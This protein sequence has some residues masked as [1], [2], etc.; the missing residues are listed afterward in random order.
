VQYRL[1]PMSATPPRVRRA[2]DEP[3]ELHDYDPLWPQRFEQEARHLR[4]LLP[5]A[6][7]GRIAHFGSTAIP[8]MVA[9][10]IVDMLVEVPSLRHVHEVIAPLLEKQGYEYFWRASWQNPLLPAYTW[11]I[12]RDAQ[13]RRTHHIHL[14]TPDAPEWERLLFRDYLMAHPPVAQAYGALK[15]RLA[16]AH[17]RDRIA[18]ARA[19]SDFIEDVMRKARAHYSQPQDCR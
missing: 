17:P 2:R 19:K 12:K 6:G 3:V 18:Y 16:K 1:L 15:R 13:G 9:K 7:L 10:P 8:G 11:F 14:L 5:Q 4:Q